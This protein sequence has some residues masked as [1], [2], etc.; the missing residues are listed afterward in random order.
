[1][2]KAIL[3]LTM[4]GNFVVRISLATTNNSEAEVDGKRWVIMVTA[5]EC[6]YV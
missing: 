4:C 2:K 3:L 5:I 6:D 1:M